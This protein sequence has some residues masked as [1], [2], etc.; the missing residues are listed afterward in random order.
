[1]SCD[2]KLHCQLSKDHLEYK[3]RTDWHSKL[4]ETEEEK[5]RLGMQNWFC[6]SSLMQYDLSCHKFDTQE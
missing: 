4:A 6:G 2:E 1:V 3:R 5:E